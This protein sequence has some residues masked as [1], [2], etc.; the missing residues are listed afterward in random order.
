M[1]YLELIG[2]NNADDAT[3]LLSVTID[4]GTDRWT[5]SDVNGLSAEFFR[6]IRSDAPAI[7]VRLS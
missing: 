4:D 2:V 3:S 1:R 7:E 6:T 5:T